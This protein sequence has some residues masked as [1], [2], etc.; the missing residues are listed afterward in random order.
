M[1]FRALVDYAMSTPWLCRRT[2]LRAYFLTALC[3]LAA[4]CSSEPEHK[5]A[6]PRKASPLQEQASPFAS[7]AGQAHKGTG[8][9]D[10][11]RSQSALAIDCPRLTDV[12]AAAGIDHE[13]R[14]G[15]Q[16]KQ[17][18][19]EATGGG[20]GWLD[21]DGDHHWDLYLN[22]GGD[23]TAD[24]NPS[25][26]RDKL[27]RNLGDGT[28][29]DIAEAAGIAELGYS[30]GLAVG[31]F[32]GD[33]FDDLYI[34]NVGPNVLFQNQGDGTFIQVTERAGV[35]EPRWSTSAAFADL[36]LDGDLDLY[37]CNYV[38]YDPK[39][40]LDCFDMYGQ[41][42]ICHPRNLAAAPDECYL[43][44][45]DG[46]FLP[47][48]KSRGL[49]G[50]GNKGLGV[51]IA[52]L[53][54][55][56][57]PDV[58]V[59]NDTEANFLFINQ[60]DATFVESAML[61]GCGL[62]MNGNRQANMGL[63][64]ADYDNNG[65]LDIYVTTYFRESNTLFRNLGPEGFQDVTGLAGL[66]T[67]TLNHLGFGAVMQD[68]NQDGHIDLFI[69]NGHIDPKEVVYEMTPQLFTFDGDTWLEC[70]HDVGGFFTH[71]FVGRGV[72]MADYDNDGKLELAVAH[73]GSNAALLRCD[74]PRGNWVKLQ[75][76]GQD[77]NR[78]GINA[79]A[80]LRYGEKT[81]MQELCAG[82][83][84]CASHQPVLCFGL[85]E[86]DEPC[87][88]DVRWPS[89]RIQTLTD[90]KVNQTLLIREPSE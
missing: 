33:G 81:T 67:P 64:I 70:K 47:Q 48:A 49:F 7:R 19:V 77:G 56:F 18:M 38:D 89:G 71:R 54:N 2:M 34:T 63:G 68:L 46:S 82:T 55:D 8:V 22:Q 39:N 17:L 15:S 9:R 40:P 73:Q 78:R 84:Y 62:D 87:S 30:Q 72:A 41:P 23:P 36:D 20:C 6:A 4:A 13:Y 59:A 66:H 11:R 24:A 86:W 51:I 35:V 32:N 85:G 12:H 88:I 83:S 45:G 10:A 58:F 75:F 42:R 57:Y 80:S 60:R 61:L 21:Y 44:Q 27:Y 76:I 65:Y 69:T 28:F 25:Q 53:N 74:S 37:V 43:N 3:I 5:S 90:V 29:L 16:G 26:P 14:N 31:D 79:R 1:R 52:D 50:D